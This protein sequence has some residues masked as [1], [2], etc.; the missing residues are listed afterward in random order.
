MTTTAVVDVKSPW[1]SKINWI[2]LI[3]AIGAIGAVFGFDIGGEDQAQIVALISAVES[4]VV[5]I[6]RTFFSSSV[7]RNS[8]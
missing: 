6:T 7:I 2:S 5:I 8:V 4:V 1:K 3:G